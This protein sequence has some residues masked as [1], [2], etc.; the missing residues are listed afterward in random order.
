VQTTST[1]QSV[2]LDLRYAEALYQYAQVLRKLDKPAQAKAQL[3]AF[4][5]ITAKEPPRNR[6]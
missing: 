1:A 3:A 4:R 5:E 6:P 2:T